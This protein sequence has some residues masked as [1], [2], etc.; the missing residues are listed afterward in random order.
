VKQVLSALLAVV[1]GTVV[2]LFNRQYAAYTMA[3][4]NKAWN[5]HNG[6]KQIR[7]LRIALCIS[8]VVLVIV[9]LMGLLGTVRFR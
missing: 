4:Q 6:P 5:L 8:G 7:L 2:I 3:W 9:G 1:V